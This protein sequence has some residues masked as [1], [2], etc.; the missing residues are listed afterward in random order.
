MGLK[1]RA[2]GIGGRKKHLD[3]E[4]H[5][6]KKHAMA[7]LQPQNPGSQRGIEG[8]AFVTRRGAQQKIENGYISM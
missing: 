4:N 1:I 2:L 6:V 8:G 3:P 5:G 7:L